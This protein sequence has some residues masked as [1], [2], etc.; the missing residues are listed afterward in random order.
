VEDTY[1]GVGTATFTVTVEALTM[2]VRVGPILDELTEPVFKATVR[3]TLG[4]LVMTKTSSFSGFADFVVNATS[5]GSE[6][7]VAIRKEGYEPQEYQAV[8]GADGELDQGSQPLVKAEVTEPPPK[9]EEDA[10]GWQYGAAIVLM[11]VILL[12]LLLLAGKRPRPSWRRDGDGE[13]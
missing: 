5:V 6:V 10:V 9:D 12:Y 4:D 13:K 7:T 1:K 2:T 3:M 8:I 11:L